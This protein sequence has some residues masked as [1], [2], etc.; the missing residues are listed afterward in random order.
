MNNDKNKKN[1]KDIDKA[2][3]NFVGQENMQDCQGEECVIKSDKSLVERINK[4]IIT[5]DGRD[6][7]I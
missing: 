7:L 5:E 2:L 3:E 6:L 1:N 4:R